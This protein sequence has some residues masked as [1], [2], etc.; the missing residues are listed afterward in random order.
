MNADGYKKVYEAIVEAI[1]FGGSREA[2]FDSPKD[3]NE[4]VQVIIHFTSKTDIP[5]YVTQGTESSMKVF[6]KEKDPKITDV[7]N[8][9]NQHYLI[10]RRMDA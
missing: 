6:T 10:V 1:L 5:F 4:A 9:V 7:E 2:Q 3:L 8:V